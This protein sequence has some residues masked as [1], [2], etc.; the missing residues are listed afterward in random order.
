M[1]FTVFGLLSGILLIIADIP[2]VINAY[3][4]RTSPHRVTWFIIFMLNV[5]AFANQSA[6]GATNSLWFVVGG[7][8]ATFSVFMISI[9]RGVGG[10]SKMDIIII[11]GAIAGIIMWQ[12][13]DSPLYSILSNTVVASLGLLPTYKKAYYNP[14]SETKVTWLIGSISSIF[15]VLSVGKIDSILLILP[16]YAFVSQAGIYLI[17]NSRSVKRR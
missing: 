15:G 6:S 9:P 2:Y 7:M 17:L 14:K 11:L 16:I 3:K 10:H 1:I 8:I 4:K 13:F 5:I 12:Q